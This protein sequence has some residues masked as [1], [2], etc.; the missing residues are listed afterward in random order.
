MKEK[1]IKTIE[2]GLHSGFS[3]LYDKSLNEKN[4]HVHQLYDFCLRKYFLAGK[5]GVSRIT[6]QKVNTPML[7]TRAIGIKIEDIAYEV[8]KAKFKDRV[9]NKYHLSYPIIDDIFLVGE[10]DIVVGKYI[11]E[12]KSMKPDDFELDTIPDRY[13]KQVQSYLA[14]IKLTNEQLNDKYGFVITFCKLQKTPQF[15]I[16]CVDYNTD[17]EKTIKKLKNDFSKYYKK[18][19]LPEKICSSLHCYSAKNCHLRNECFKE[20]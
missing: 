10:I 17:V 11:F 20:E 9:K 6:K 18:D 13:I 7:M 2:D 14:L 19:E 8:L 3:K 12:I 1:I 16:F 4:I 5:L 15:K